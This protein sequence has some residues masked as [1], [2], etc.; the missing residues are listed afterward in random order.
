ME[1]AMRLGTKGVP[2][3]RGYRQRFCGEVCYQLLL[4]K[5]LQYISEDV[6]RELRAGYDRVIQMLYRLSRRLIVSVG[7]EFTSTDTVVFR[8]TSTD[9]IP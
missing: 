6:Y 3:I 1:G 7:H 8:T 9:L 2:P 5:D 4:A